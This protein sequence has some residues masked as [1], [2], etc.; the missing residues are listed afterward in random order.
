MKLFNAIAAVA[1]IGASL[2]TATSVFADFGEA[3]TGN[4]ISNQISRFEAWCGKSGNNCL[5]EFDRSENEIVINSSSRV[6][7]DS[8]LDF[9]YSIQKRKCMF[10]LFTGNNCAAPIQSDRVIIDIEYRKLDQQ[11][12]SARIIFGNLPVGRKFIGQLSSFTS[13]K[14]D[15]GT[16]NRVDVVD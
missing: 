3:D 15:E 9:A 7:A 5:V 16:A 13:I 2:G 4:N 10:T 8:I 1:V 6:K 12:S 14:G 11:V